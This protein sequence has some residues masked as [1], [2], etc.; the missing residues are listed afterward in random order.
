MFYPNGDYTCWDHLTDAGQEMV[1]DGDVDG[2]FT[3]SQLATIARM[4]AED[5]RGQ[6]GP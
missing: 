3:P 2:E 5:P 4:E 1:N 6:E